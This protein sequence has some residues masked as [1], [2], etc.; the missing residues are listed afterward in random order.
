MLLVSA[1]GS[2]EGV[3]SLEDVVEEL[4]GREIVDETDLFIDMHKRTSVQRV[5]E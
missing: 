2:P 3:V 1:G 5:R 4:L